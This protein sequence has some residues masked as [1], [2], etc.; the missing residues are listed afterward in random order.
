MIALSGPVEPGETWRMEQFSRAYVAAVAAGAACGMACPDPD[1]DS[2]DLTLTRKTIHGVRRSPR[3]D[4]QI[5]ATSAD[6]L[7][8][9]EVKFPLSIKNYEELRATNFLVPRILVMVVMPSD[10]IDWLDHDETK[11]ALK[12]CGYWVSLYGAPATSNTTSIT[13]SL[14]RTQVLGVQALDQIFTRLTNGGMP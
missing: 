9:E 2:V 6:C 8:A 3:L 1:D 4:L 10:I 5:K 13:I 12:K 14:P 7:G 11:L